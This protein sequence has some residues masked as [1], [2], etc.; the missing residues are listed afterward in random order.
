MIIKYTS[1][2]LIIAFFIV[3]TIVGLRDCD[4]PVTS[5]HLHTTKPEDEHYIVQEKLPEHVKR[6]KIIAEFFIGDYEG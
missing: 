2:V 6:K 4:K 1:L 3:I 5:H